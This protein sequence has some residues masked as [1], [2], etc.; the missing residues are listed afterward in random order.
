MTEPVVDERRAQEVIEEFETEARTRPLRGAWA[1]FATAFGVAVAFLAL[2]Y[3]MAGA[4]IP[5]TNIQI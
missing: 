5:F 1:T 4:P 2:Y 3:A